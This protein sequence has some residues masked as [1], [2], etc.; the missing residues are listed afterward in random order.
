MDFNKRREIFNRLLANMP[1]LDCPSSHIFNNRTT[2][3]KPACETSDFNPGKYGNSS[4]GCRPK[5]C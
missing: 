1:E 3:E 2:Q 4:I 5:E